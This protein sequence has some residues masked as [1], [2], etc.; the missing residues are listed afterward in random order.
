MKTDKNTLLIISNNCQLSIIHCKFRKWSAFPSHTPYHYAYNST[1]I[2]SDP[3]G[4]APEKEKD[5]EKL[6]VVM[7]GPGDPSEYY[8]HTEIDYSNPR[9]NCGLGAMQY[10]SLAEQLFYAMMANGGGGG[11]RTGTASWAYNGSTTTTTTITNSDGTTTTTTNTTYHFTTYIPTTNGTMIVPTDVQQSGI[12]AGETPE[13]VMLAFVGGINDILGADPTYFDGLWGSDVSVNIMNS[14]EIT[15]QGQGGYAGLHSGVKGTNKSVITLA[16][17]VLT[18]HTAYPKYPNKD[19]G[20][21]PHEP[22]MIIAHEFA[23]AN[24]F[25]LTGDNFFSYNW[26]LQELFAIT[27]T[28]RIQSFYNDPQRKTWSSIRPIWGMF[29]KSTW[30]HYQ[31]YGY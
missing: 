16:G 20:F 4:L 7:P 29:Y 27:N 8:V 5:R 25:A 30:W 1:M 10:A 22:Y 19:G 18:G 6:M 15:F 9:Y 31:I 12:S 24:H 26:Q 23:H 17:D 2:W 14:N 13:S 11:G 28:N 21:S 3:S